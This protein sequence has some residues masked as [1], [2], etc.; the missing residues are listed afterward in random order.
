MSRSMWELSIEKVNMDDHPL[1]LFAGA[2]DGSRSRR[3]RL[4]RFIQWQLETKDKWYMPE[5]V[6]WRDALMADGK[7]N[8]KTVQAYLDT[9]RAAYRRIIKNN[10]FRDL[11][12]EQLDNE[13]SHSDKQ[14]LVS[15]YYIR[16]ANQL[17]PDNAPVSVITVQDE[18][19]REHHWLTPAQVAML[20]QSPGIDTWLGLRDT[21]LIALL[22][23]T[24]IRAAEAVALE[25]DDLRAMLDGLLALRV[26][27][28]KGL[29]QRLIPYGAQDWALTFVDA[30][31]NTI[32]QKTGPVFVGLR[33][34]DHLYLDKDNQRQKLAVN[35]V[36]TCLRR[37][38]ISLDGVL[39]TIEPH[40]L[41]RTYARRLYLIGT[42]LTAIGQNMGHTNQ[43]TTLGYIGALDG[44]HRAPKDAY[45]TAWLRPMW[46]ALGQQAKK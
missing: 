13:M 24:G 30:W 28:G 10:E 35:A 21:A 29:K 14:A 26:K 38:P 19:D 12:Y 41:R 11:L 32:Q 1:M 25:V 9:V 2:E 46:K 34:N 33:K 15:E 17:D 31:L 4:N 16:L 37:Y 7:V 23:C 18:D 45:G 3:S 5:L 42:D 39:T 43:E 20:V 44:K 27:A 8:N 6:N 40:D 36:G 22:L